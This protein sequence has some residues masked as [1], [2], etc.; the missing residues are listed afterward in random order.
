[1]I[2]EEKSWPKRQLQRECKAL[3]D[4]LLWETKLDREVIYS[5][6]MESDGW[7]A[8]L[9]TRY[10]SEAVE[11]ILKLPTV[12]RFFYQTKANRFKQLNVWCIRA[13]S[14][15]ELLDRLRDLPG[16]RVEP[17]AERVSVHA[18]H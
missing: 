4:R 13:E 7:V 10:H 12:D 16:L 18:D 8:L 11:L 15:G 1:M 14:A 6:P 2:V 3:S 17:L 9:M 5:H